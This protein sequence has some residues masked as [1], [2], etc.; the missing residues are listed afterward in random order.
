MMDTG[1]LLN[2]MLGGNQY[3][4]YNYDAVLF[5]CSMPKMKYIVNFDAR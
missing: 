5:I 2:V 3:S 1:C 4:E